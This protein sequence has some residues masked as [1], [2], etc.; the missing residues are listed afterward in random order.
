MKYSLFL[1]VLYVS[2]ISACSRCSY[3]SACSTC[4]SYSSSC[5]HHCPNNSRGIQFRSFNYWKSAPIGSCMTC[6]CLRDQRVE[7]LTCTSKCISPGS[8]CYISKDN[9]LQYPECCPKIVC[10]KKHNYG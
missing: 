8:S 10:P 9:S 5:R 1:V 7:C 2:Y 4:S 3:T 6:R